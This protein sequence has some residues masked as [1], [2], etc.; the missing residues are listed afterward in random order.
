MALRSLDLKLGFA[1]NN[2]CLSCPQAHRR[3]LGN[4]STLEVKEK[5]GEGRKKGDEQV[6][7]TGGEP[8]VRPDL[9]EVIEYAKGIGYK[10]I[11]LQSNARMLSYKGFCRKV[12]AAGATSFM[13]GI[14]G[15]NAETHDYLVQSPGAF[16]QAVAGVRNLKAAGKPVSI[17]SV[18]NKVNYLLV[19]ETAKFFVG[20]NVD[21]LQ[22]AFMHCT[23]NALKNIDLLLPRKSEVMPY[24]HRGLDVGIKAGVRMRVEA[25]PFCFLHGYEVCSSE[26]HAPYKEVRDAEG[27]RENFNEDRRKAK[28]K[29]PQCKACR[30]DLVC[31][32][33]WKEYAEKFGFSE[34]KPVPGQ[35][36][37][38]AMEIINS[39]R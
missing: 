25:I 32:G 27:L 8:T 24:I 17:N 30:F 1:C 13:L 39:D 11:Q 37:K 29:G 6:V 20:L 34:L 7:L 4:L 18:V 10:D 19:P 28:R 3:H 31:S 5:L 33:P 36:I 14:H 22:F 9:L 23:G 26:I 15:P 12:I 38:S 16:A 2:N 35:K 21:Q